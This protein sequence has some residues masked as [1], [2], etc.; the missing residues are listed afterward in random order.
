MKTPV[1]PVTPTTPTNPT[2][3]AFGWDLKMT[4]S[5]FASK[6]AGGVAIG[7]GTVVGATLA[8]PV[9]TAIEKGATKTWEGAKWLGGKIA[10][11][12]TKTPAPTAA[13]NPTPA[14]T[15]ETEQNQ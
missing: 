6:A 3:K 2:M 15:T 14:A 10:G 12:F 7:F 11:V 5:D 1:T 4:P 8:K 9:M 13:V